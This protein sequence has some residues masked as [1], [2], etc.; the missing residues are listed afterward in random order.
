MVYYLVTKKY[1]SK[2]YVVN[3]HTQMIS[4]QSEEQTM[5]F[6]RKKNTSNQKQERCCFTQEKN[7]TSSQKSHS[8][9]SFAPKFQPFIDA[10]S[11]QSPRFASGSQTFNEKSFSR[12]VFR[13][14]KWKT[15]LKLERNS[16]VYFSVGEDN[17]C[18]F[19]HDVTKIQTKKTID[20]TE[21]LLS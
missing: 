18:W 5:F 13:I 7:D 8:C 9:V 14:K 20:R 3:F 4:S 21:F 12:R 17:Y 15:S 1:S 11:L 10:C 2:S 6:A 19:S 16:F